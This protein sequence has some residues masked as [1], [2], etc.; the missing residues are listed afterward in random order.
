MAQ[1]RLIKNPAVVCT[2]MD[3]GGVLL[4]LETTAYYSLNRTALR[5]WN[6]IEQAPTLDEVATRL[7]SEFAVDYEQAL[8][9]AKRLV[10]TLEH[11]RLIRTES[12]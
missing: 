9:S 10:A 4:D 7:T 11:E 6:L 5:I 8:A 3:E 2:D 1:S 12:A